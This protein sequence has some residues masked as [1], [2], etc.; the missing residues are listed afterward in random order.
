MDVV[1]TSLMRTRPRFYGG[2]DSPH[3]TVWKMCFL[4]NVLHI[5]VNDF[6]SF[7][8]RAAAVAPPGG[9]PSLS[10]IVLLAS[11]LS[12]CLCLDGIPENSASIHHH[13]CPSRPRNERANVIHSSILISTL[14][15]TGHTIL[16]T[17]LSGQRIILLS[18]QAGRQK[19]PCGF[20]DSAA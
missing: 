20:V 11:C 16:L 13:V 12:V 9:L 4:F 6:H 17:L 18:L 1:A 15:G 5:F 7:C 10:S 14:C 8:W 3:V 19:R 2:T